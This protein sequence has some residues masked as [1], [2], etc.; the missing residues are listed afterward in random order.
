M[1]L[2]TDMHIKTLLP[3]I[4]IMAVVALILGKCL[5]KRSERIRMLPFQ[6]VAVV[7][8]VLEI[9][10]QVISF[11]KGYDLYHIPLHFC[12]L[13]IFM[14]PLMSFYRGKHQNAVRGITAGLCT[15]V[16][17]LMSVYPALIYTAND[18]E[19]YFQSL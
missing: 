3:S 1:E 5:A 16:F 11:S 8:F 9:F 14:L 12:S 15:S 17:F 13:F 18:V 4:L 19:Q 6:I 10:K 2:W 7:L